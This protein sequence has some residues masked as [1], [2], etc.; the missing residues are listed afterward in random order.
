MKTFLKL[1]LVIIFIFFTGS[2]SMNKNIAGSKA[3]VSSLSDNVAIK[4]GSLIYGLPLTVINVKVETERV[5]E[6][7]GPYAR[8]A[9]DMLGLT[10]VIRNETENWSIKSV[11]IQTH[12]ELDPSEFYVI[13]A[14]S[15]FHTNMLSLKKAGLIMDLNPESFYQGEARYP[16]RAADLNHLRVFD[17]GADE[18]FQARNDTAYRLINVDTTFIRIPYLVEKKQKLSLDQL[19]DRA[20]RRLMEL[21]DGKH[22]ILTGEANVFP[23]SQAAIN[24]INRLEKD[25]TELF[26]GKIWKENRTFIFQI[27]PRKNMTGKQVTL[28]RFSENTGPAADGEKTGTP[29]IIEFLPEE[30]TKKLTVVQ[31]QISSSTSKFE[32]LFYRVPDVVA[33]KITLENEILSNSRQLIYQFGEVVQ[34][35][36][37]FIIGR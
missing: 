2:C 18:Y 36:A 32:K 29:V 25:Y 24:E 5:I 10:D 34:L 9:G 23:Q 33:V 35:P 14:S 11:A 7:P 8:Y 6:K 19:A 3:V 17:L 4:D 1:S 27:I 28:F 21:R 22:L 30:K 12:Q 31:K 15:I 13:R 37:N 16:D 26:S 20:A